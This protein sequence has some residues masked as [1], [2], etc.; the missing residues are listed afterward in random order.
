MF[1]FFISIISCL[2]FLGCATKEPIAKELPYY[3]KDKV[4]LYL[5]N[6]ETE[7]TNQKEYIYTIESKN[8]IKKINVCYSQYS[9]SQLEEDYY[10]IKAVQ[11]DKISPFN[12]RQDHEYFN[13]FLEKGK[14]YILKIDTNYDSVSIGKFI[15]STVLDNSLDTKI[16]IVKIE[17]LEA[18]NIFKEMKNHTN[19]FG[20]RPYPLKSED[21]NTDDFCIEQALKNTF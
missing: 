16:K 3:N 6:N 13:S 2:L 1:K 7:L 15:A 5:L 9:Y 20:K 14:S 4:N 12:D 10:N 21:N 11:R 19:L 8:F 17:K 18:L